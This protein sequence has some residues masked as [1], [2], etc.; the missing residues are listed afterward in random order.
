[1]TTTKNAFDK[2]YN[3]YGCAFLILIIIIGAI[4]EQFDKCNNSEKSNTDKIANQN[5][6]DFEQSQKKYEDSL[7]LDSI[8]NPKRYED[9]PNLNLDWKVESRKLYITNRD[10]FTYPLTLI[11][12]STNELDGQNPG[13]EYTYL[14]KKPIASG[15]KAE[16]SLDEFST[17]LIHNNGEKL[18]GNGALYLHSNY[19]HI[20]H[21][22][23]IA[24]KFWG[25]PNPAKS[26]H[27]K[28]DDTELLGETQIELSNQ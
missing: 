27:E 24:M 2:K 5:S 25:A 13:M 28:Y 18:K 22:K 1:M 16:L 21:I 12:I 14:N 4:I 26:Q 6:E 11:A 3:K 20:K 8:K 10:S 19:E 17:A 23:I 9:I 7:R 15:N